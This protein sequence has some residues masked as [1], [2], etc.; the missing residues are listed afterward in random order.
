[1]NTS[2]SSP[3]RTPARGSNSLAGGRGAR[4]FTLIELMIVLAVVGIMAGIGAPAMTAT[5]RSVQLSTA[6]ND[7]L[8]SL[9]MARSE[10]IKRK[11]RV[12]VCKSADGIMCAHGGGWQQ[13]WLVFHDADNDG[14]HDA[15]EAVL[16]RVA[17][18]P[19]EL[20]VT[21]NLNV[22]RYVSYAP[23]GTT[24]LLGGSFQAGTITL[25]RHSAGAT[26][27]RQIVVSSSG[28]PR[29]LKT[30]LDECV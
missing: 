1:M 12:A 16:Q 30:R 6:S 7:L 4:G 5:V 28:R 21:G 25:C 23:T 8:W 13:G 14:E 26:D 17:P 9:F 20:H 19:A 24:K 29:V 27:G 3:I 10:A 2:T 11:S 15:G 22:A 18:L